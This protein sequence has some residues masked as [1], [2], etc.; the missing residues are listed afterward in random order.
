MV[1]GN[2][3]T[4]QVEITGISDKQQITVLFCG[5]FDDCF[6]PPQIIYQGKTSA[7]LPN[8]TFPSDWHVTCTPNHWSNENE[9]MEYI[10]LIILPYINQEYK[11]F[12]LAENHPALAVFDVFRGI[13]A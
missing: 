6:L 11:E 7:C 2:E 10:E 12:D 1:N 3:G 4:K 5:T 13:S 9:M 8:F